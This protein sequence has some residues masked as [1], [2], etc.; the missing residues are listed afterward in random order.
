M[1]PVKKFGAGP[2]V[3]L[4]RVLVPRLEEA[5]A[6]RSGHSGR[7]VGFQLQPEQRVVLLQSERQAGTLATLLFPRS[8]LSG[9]YRDHG[10]ATIATPLRTLYGGGG[11]RHWACPPEAQQTP[12]SRCKNTDTA[13]CTSRVLPGPPP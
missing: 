7:G 11:V 2:H 4:D 10:I 5:A 8:P 12:L 3:L 6:Q 13:A 9:S 1:V